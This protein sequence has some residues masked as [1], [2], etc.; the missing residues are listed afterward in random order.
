MLNKLVS[1]SVAAL[2]SF[3]LAALAQGLP[4]DEMGGPDFEGQVEETELAFAG[5]VAGEELGLGGGIGI[6]A[7]GPSGG[8]NLSD[9][10]LE[11][12]YKIKN[13]YADSEDQKKTELKSLGRQ[14]KALLMEEKVDRSAVQALNK[15]ISGLKADLAEIKLSMRLDSMDVLS[16]EQR[17]ELRHKSLQRQV[18][19]GRPKHG[20]MGGRGGRGGPG[21]PGGGFRG[22]CG[23]GEAGPKA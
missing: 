5:G 12:I 6:G 19:G 9:E 22:G 23:A 2:L 4:D 14:M 17:Q 1:L 7:H 15:K 3:N 10:Q 20:R 8:L 16:T 18:M 11:K 21:G 13:S